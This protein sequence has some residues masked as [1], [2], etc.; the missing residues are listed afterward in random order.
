MFEI[1][2]GDERVVR[3]WIEKYLKEEKEKFTQISEINV[4]LQ[5]FGVRRKDFGLETRLER[6]LLRLSGVNVVDVG[7]RNTC[8]IDKAPHPVGPP[9]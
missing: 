4:F 9:I 2:G 6:C 7:R 3:E 8:L 1:A 5:T